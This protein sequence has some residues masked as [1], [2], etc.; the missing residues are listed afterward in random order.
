MIDTATA[1][2][3]FVAR[4]LQRF[5]PDE[6]LELVAQ[7]PEAAMPQAIR[8][9]FAMECARL[10]KGEDFFGVDDE[11]WLNLEIADDILTITSAL[12]AS[13]SL[14]ILLGHVLA[15]VDW[16]LITE[17]CL[18]VPEEWEDTHKPQHR[19]RH[20]FSNVVGRDPKTGETVE[21]RT[22]IAAEAAGFRRQA[23]SKAAKQGT[24]YSGLLWELRPITAEDSSD[25]SIQ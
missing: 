4:W 24:M 17:R 14:L 9:L 21:F 2:S 11:T 3:I 5:K 18:D 16:D 8:R 10:L 7:A 12:T 22:L 19:S 15:D 1:A 20:G 6:L 23:I 25:E 13:S